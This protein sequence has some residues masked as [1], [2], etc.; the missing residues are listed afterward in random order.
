MA[1]GAGD[2]ALS[3]GIGD[4]KLLRGGMTWGYCHAEK[5]ESF[6]QHARTPLPGTERTLGP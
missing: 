3:D 1:G 6:R 2:G 5:C 4:G